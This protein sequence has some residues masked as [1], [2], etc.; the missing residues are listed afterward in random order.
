MKKIMKRLPIILSA[1]A[2]LA[3]ST[4]VVLAQGDNGQE[5]DKGKHTGQVKHHR[6]RGLHRGKVKHH[7]RT[8][9]H[10]AKTNTMEMKKH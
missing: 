3:S 5:K 7:T 1:L 9:S 2:I 4:V 6:N 8:R 10:R